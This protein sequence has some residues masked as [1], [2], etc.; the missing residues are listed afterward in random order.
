MCVE[1][2]RS[3][4]FSRGSFLSAAAIAAAP[5]FAEPARALDAVQRLA[6]AQMELPPVPAG[7]SEP[8]ARA[9]RIARASPFART[10]YAAALSL[11]GSIGDAGLRAKVH[12]LLADP[13]PTYARAYATPESRAALRDALARAGLVAADAPVDGIFPAG[14]ENARALQPFWAAPGSGDDSHHCYPGGLLVHELFNARMAEQFARTYDTIYFA[15]RSAVDRDCVIAAALYH[16]VMKTAVF[17][18]NADG[19]LFK[20]LEI[21]A[22]GGHH[23][24]SGA[25]AIARGHDA[26]FVT[27]LLSAHAAPSLGDGKK[28]VSWCRAAAMIAGV[29]PVE[30]GL[31]AGR[32]DEYVLAALPPAEAF[33]NHLSDHDY[34]LTVA[35]VHEV[36]PYVDAL[37]PK[38]GVSATDATAVRWWRHGILARASAVGLYHELTRGETAFAAAVARA[39]V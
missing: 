38:F 29:D 12:A 16:D 4:L 5:F 30:F 28:V 21:G 3:H 18:Y 11:A 34:V 7:L 39:N 26:R 27:V 31:L 37:A 10:N 2:K 32:G 14:T 22:T 25:E 17:Q 9:A 36:A 35:A 13:R 15:G 24:L 20:E 33:V 19:T 23:C 1:G 8:N 6:P